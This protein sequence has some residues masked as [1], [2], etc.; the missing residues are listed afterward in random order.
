MTAAIAARRQPEQDLTGVGMPARAQSCVDQIKRFDRVRDSAPGD[1][2]P[3]G[4]INQPGRRV[5]HCHARADPQ[6]MR[7]ETPALR[8][9]RRAWVSRAGSLED[10]FDVGPDTQ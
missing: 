3:G 9:P 6:R 8:C 10:L 7:G 2:V 4:V 1:S 5:L